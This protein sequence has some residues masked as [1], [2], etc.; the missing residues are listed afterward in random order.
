MVRK[1]EPGELQGNARQQALSRLPLGGLNR[2]PSLLES[3]GGLADVDLGEESREE[4][5][6]REPMGRIADGARRLARIGEHIGT[7]HFS[8]T[9]QDESE[10]PQFSHLQPP[11]V[12]R[13]DRPLGR[14]LAPPR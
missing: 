14:K 10:L 8:D 1:P 6:R 2:F 5:E 4:R 9:T 13:V 12:D 7:A 11:V 3:S